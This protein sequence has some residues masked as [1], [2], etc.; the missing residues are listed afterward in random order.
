MNNMNGS[1]KA[2]SQWGRLFHLGWLLLGLLQL[3]MVSGCGQSASA[4]DPLL[5]ASSPSGQSTEEAGTAVAVMP[6]RVS[7]TFFESQVTGAIRLQGSDG[8]SGADTQSAIAWNELAPTDPAPADSA[9][10]GTVLADF[11]DHQGCASF[12]DANGVELCFNLMGDVDSFGLNAKEMSPNGLGAYVD[13]QLGQP[14][15]G[16]AWDVHLV[17]AARAPAAGSASKVSS[18]TVSF[19]AK[20][21]A[22][23]SCNQGPV[24]VDVTVQRI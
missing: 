22:G 16:A 4:S 6:V 7:R 3:L 21:A 2:K 9:A 20:P 1:L 8:N 12:Q 15:P 11:R 14:C 10:T 13:R 5:S 24:K 23:S 17:N 19:V 18:F